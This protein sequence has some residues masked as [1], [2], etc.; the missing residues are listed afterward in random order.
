MLGSVCP[1]SGQSVGLLSPYLN[2][3]IVNTFF[4]QFSREVDP[5]VHV[6][7]VWDQ[8]GFHTSKELKIPQNMTII[9]L[10]AYSPELN[11]ADVQLGKGQARLG[12]AIFIKWLRRVTCAGAQ[13][14]AGRLA[15]G[16]AYCHL[17]AMR[18]TRHVCYCPDSTRSENPNV[19]VGHFMP[20]SVS[21][22]Y[23]Q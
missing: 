15:S 8:A 23:A 5:D 13:L 12:K 18:F 17:L 1:A 6:V 2:T 14:G 3:Q 19:R 16:V 20:E 4:G 9:T 22:C 10:P 7:M 11:P 21:Q